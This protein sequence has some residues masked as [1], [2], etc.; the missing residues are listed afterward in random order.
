MRKRRSGDTMLLWMGAGIC[1]ATAVSNLCCTMQLADPRALYEIIR[2]GWQR[3]AESRIYAAVRVLPVRLLQTALVVQVC[4]SRLRQMGCRL[5]LLCGG[6]GLGAALVVMSRARGLFGLLPFLASRFPQGLCYLA[7]WGLY[8]YAGLEE[9]PQQ[10]WRLRA[11]T[12]ALLGGGILLEIC[13]SPG[14]AVKIL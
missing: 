3:A 7:A 2:A 4:R 8:L 13:A 1:L 12:A 9:L 6:C 10:E 14:L 5:L 11:V